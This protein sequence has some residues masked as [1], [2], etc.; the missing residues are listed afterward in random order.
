[1]KKGYSTLKKL[2]KNNKIQMLED[3]QQKKMTTNIWT[4]QSEKLKPW[5]FSHE[6][7]LVVGN[8]SRT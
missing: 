4:I 5:T 1:M 8:K 2:P 6:R 7:L 3:Y